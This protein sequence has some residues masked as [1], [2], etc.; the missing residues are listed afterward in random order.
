MAAVVVA[1]TES[2]DEGHGGEVPL[3]SL[4]LVLLAVAVVHDPHVHAADP[5]W[6]RTGRDEKA[7]CIHRR[8]TGY[9]G[10][11]FVCTR[12]LAWDVETSPRPLLCIRVLPFK[13]DG[14]WPEVGR[15]SGGWEGGGGGEGS[16]KRRR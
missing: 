13:R 10:R 8:Q 1:R 6:L 14:R 5:I 12:Y 2:L 7:S 9:E 15:E 4:C 3:A 11:V 16:V